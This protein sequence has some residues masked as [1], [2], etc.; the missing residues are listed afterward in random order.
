VTVC[1]LR[2]AAVAAVR[3]RGAIWRIAKG[4]RRVASGKERRIEF[5]EGAP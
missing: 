4:S 3:M 5:E 2:F 1:A